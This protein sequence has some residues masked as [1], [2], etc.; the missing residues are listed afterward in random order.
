[1]TIPRI[2]EDVQHENEESFEGDVAESEQGVRYYAQVY[3]TPVWAAFPWQVRL[4]GEALLTFRFGDKTEVIPHQ[5][6]LARMVG[7]DVR[8]VQRW[9][10]LAEKYGAIRGAYRKGRAR[11]G[12]CYDVSGLLLAMGL[13]PDNL[14][15]SVPGQT[16]QHSVASRPSLPP[17]TRQHSVLSRHDN[18]VSPLI[19]R[20]TEE[21]NTKDSDTEGR[22]DTG[23]SSDE[24]FTP[25]SPNERPGREERPSRREPVV[26]SSVDVR[27]YLTATLGFSEADAK[28]FLRKQPHWTR[29][30]W[31]EARRQYVA[32]V[33]LK[34]I[35][36]QNDRAMFSRFVEKHNLDGRRS[37]RGMVAEFTR[38]P[39][40]SHENPVTGG[41]ARQALRA[42][43]DRGEYVT[44]ADVW[45]QDAG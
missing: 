14:S 41:Y 5:D 4:I 22:S 35:E 20:D 1:M 28:G 34:G 30:E 32:W 33:E 13:D 25:L 9:L 16:R 3:V 12:R 2:A 18:I 24:G 10:E 11:I 39:T 38:V 29:S 8:T 42:G 44:D 21:E 27:D 6:T 26:A 17:E 7:R 15:T 31:Q 36:P 43:E 23:S 19:R 40:R 45:R 37:D